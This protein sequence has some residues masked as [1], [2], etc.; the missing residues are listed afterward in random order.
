LKLNSKYKLTTEFLIENVEYQEAVVQHFEK[1]AIDVEG[2]W[3]VPQ[4]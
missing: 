3:K 1:T 2:V 4:N